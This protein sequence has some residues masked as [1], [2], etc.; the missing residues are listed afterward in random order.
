VLVFYGKFTEIYDKF[1]L[2]ILAFSPQACHLYNWL[3]LTKTK[4]TINF[5]METQTVYTNHWKAFHDSLED[6]I[7]KKCKE[8]VER[9]PGIS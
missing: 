3:P 4:N 8:Q 7:A 9:I 1:L 6:A 2:L 5:H